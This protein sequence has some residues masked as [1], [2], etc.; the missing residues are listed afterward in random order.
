FIEFEVRG[1][2]VR[3]LLIVIEEEVAA[4]GADL[5]RIFY[6]EQPAGCV[7]LVD[8]L[9]SDVAIAV[10]PEPVEIVMKPVPGELVLRRRSLP[11]IVMH[12]RGHRLHSRA[13]DGIPPLVAQ[14]A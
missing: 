4:D 11:Q 12:A 10:I 3:R 14:S 6:A 1:E 8:A 7:D 9:V 2:R 13:P 5:G